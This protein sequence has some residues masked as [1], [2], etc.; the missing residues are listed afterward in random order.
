MRTR[1]T[2]A[3]AGAF[4][5]RSGILLVD[6]LIYM[7]VFAVILGLAAEAFYRTL[8]HATRLNANAADIA[9]ALHAGEQ[10]RADVR[11]AIQPPQLIRDGEQVS[12]RLPQRAGEIRYRFTEDTVVREAQPGSASSEVLSGVKRSEFV[13]DARQQVVAWRWEI[14]LRGKTEA[15]RVAPLFTFQAVSA[16]ESTP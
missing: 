9:R 6:C 1:S 11:A 2:M 4:R 12:L 14:E 8:E 7:A 3:L 5:R 13:R 10:W 15:S 16:K